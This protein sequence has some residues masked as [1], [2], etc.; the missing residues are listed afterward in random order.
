M[1]TRPLDPAPDSI[2]ARILAKRMNRPRVDANGR[3]ID[4]KASRR[5][6]TYDAKGQLT[7]VQTVSHEDA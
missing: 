5:R 2:Y 4:P 1:T 6:F 3:P 7:D